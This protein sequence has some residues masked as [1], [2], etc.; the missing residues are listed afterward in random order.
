[1]IHNDIIE[2]WATRAGQRERYTTTYWEPLVTVVFD[3][4]RIV[5]LRNAGKLLQRLVMRNR[6]NPHE[7]AWQAL[8]DRRAEVAYV[9]RWHLD[10]WRVW[11]LQVGG[12]FESSIYKLPRPIF[13]PVRIPLSWMEL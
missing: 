12:S 1:M 6:D 10:R 4:G 8:R 13:V 9:I 11:C 3:P 7:A 2:P 5:P